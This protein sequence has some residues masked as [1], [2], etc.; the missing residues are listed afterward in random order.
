MLVFDIETDGFLDVL[1]RIH[2]L[3]I[4]DTGNGEITRY[5]DQKNGR[6][7]VSQGLAMLQTA[8]AIGVP[9]CGHNVID[10]DIPAILKLYPEFRVKQSLVVDTIVVTRVTHPDTWDIDNKLRRSGKLPGN[11]AG[12][13]SLEAWGHRLGVMKGDFKGPWEVWTPEMEDYNEQDVVVT[14]ALRLRMEA[15]KVRPDD[16]CLELE[17]AV[18]WII[19]RQKA[20]GFL[21]DRE[22]AEALYVKLAKRRVELEGRLQGVFPP[23][24]VM[25][26]VKTPKRDNLTRGYV[27]DAPFTAVRLT[28]FN[29][30]S[31]HHVANRLKHRYGWK[32]TD[33]TTTGEPKIDEGVLR[34]MSFPEAK[35]LE[36]FFTV[37]KRIGQIAEGKEAWFNHVKADGRI[38]GSV[39]PNGAVTGR[40]T[41][42]YPN[43]AQTPAVYSPYGKECRACFT[44]A[45]GKLQVGADAAALEGCCLA[46]FMAKYDDGAYVYVVTKGRKEEGTDVHST[47]KRAIEIDSREDAKTWFY[48]Y[49]YGAGDEKLGSIITKMRAPSKNRKRG[50]QSRASFV[51]NLPALGMLVKAVKGAAKKRKGFLRGLDGRWLPVRSDHAALN[52]LLQSA[53]AVLMKRALVILDNN[54][55]KEGYAPGTNYEFIANV[56]DEWQLEV[57]EGIAEKIGA[58]AVDAIRLAGESFGFRCPLSGEYRVGRTWADTH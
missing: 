34:A 33:F 27:K 35:L 18:A 19:S 31:R 37:D 7:P 55:Q 23:F 58:M 53:G 26:K 54:L 57:D 5:N 22:K 47:T 20:H 17:H 49:L 51:K 3:V 39:N 1:T 29:P 28:L 24:Y 44:V 16:T 14:D 52:T 10:F 50:A 42:A 9:I 45:P 25:E 13:H 43:V 6:P 46:G 8:M 56:H 4:K 41:H 36:E 15:S 48:A 30:G 21:F 12:R 2:C 32:P 38:H 40:M 11:L